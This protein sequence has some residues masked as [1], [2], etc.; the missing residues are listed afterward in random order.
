[1]IK[2]EQIALTEYLQFS[3]LLTTKNHYLSLFIWVEYS[4]STKRGEGLVHCSNILRKKNRK[5]KWTDTPFIA[6]KFNKVKFNKVKMYKKLSE[7]MLD[8]QKTKE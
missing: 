8:E 2:A 7:L 5:T 1:M 3:F 6:E 4:I